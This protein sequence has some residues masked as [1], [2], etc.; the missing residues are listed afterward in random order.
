MKREPTSDRDREA[1]AKTQTRPSTSASL[2]SRS[3]W[4]IGVIAAL[5]LLVAVGAF[6]FVNQRSA[7]VNQAD[8]LAKSASV[9]FAHGDFAHAETALSQVVALRSNDATA[10]SMLGRSREAQGKLAGAAQ[11]YSASLEAHPNQADVLCRLAVMQRSSGDNNKAIATLDEAVRV[12]PSFFPARL[13]LAQIYAST[14]ATADERTQLDAVIA[15]RPVG[16]D[17]KT[18]EGRRDALK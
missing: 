17:V 9:A 7:K 11:A 14:G 1:V 4:I 10:Q 5:V 16:V 15:L 2:K 12:N 6:W 3:R 18:L 8:D 13:L